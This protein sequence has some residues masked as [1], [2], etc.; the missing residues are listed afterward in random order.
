[1]CIFILFKYSQNVPV[2]CFK[3]VFFLKRFH[4]IYVFKNK[5]LID[6]LF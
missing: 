4:N 5:F 6:I 3:R 1:M 2:D